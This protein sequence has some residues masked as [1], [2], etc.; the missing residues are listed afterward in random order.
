MATPASEIEILRR[1][2]L[3]SEDAD[4]FRFDL[5]F[6]V[7]RCIVEYSDPDLLK[8]FPSWVGEL[9]HE[10]CEVYRQ[11]GRYGLISNLGE[12]DH[13]EMVDKLVKLLEPGG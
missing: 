11:H 9:V 5:A 7:A 6:G 10:M 3:E 2:F 12:V 4:L 8:Q 1:E 13:S